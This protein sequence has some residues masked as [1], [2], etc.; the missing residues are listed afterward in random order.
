[1]RGIVAA[2]TAVVLNRTPSSGKT[3]T[4]PAPNRARAVTAAD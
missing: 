4:A 3:S 1:M 2:G